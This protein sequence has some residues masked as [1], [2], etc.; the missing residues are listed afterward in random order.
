MLNNSNALIYFKK[1]WNRYIPLYKL[2]VT[3]NSKFI[4]DPGTNKILSCE[5]HVFFI[6]KLIKEIEEIYKIVKEK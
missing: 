4:Y 2:F 5:D 6:L 1:K 3:D